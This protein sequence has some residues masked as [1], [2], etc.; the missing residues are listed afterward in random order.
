[1]MQR[2]AVPRSITAFRGNFNWL[3][4]FYQTPVILDQIMYP[5]AEHAFQAEKTSDFNV[6]RLIAG[7]NTSTEAKRLGRAVNLVDGWNEYKRYDAMSRV[8]AA[9]FSPR[10]QLAG[11]LLSTGDAVLIE[12]NSWHDVVWGRCFCGRCLEGCNFLGYTIMLRR[13]ALGGK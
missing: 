13:R 11:W 9:K 8:I 7:A 3:S 1:M 12:G 2:S 5:S 6:R 4:N 10:S